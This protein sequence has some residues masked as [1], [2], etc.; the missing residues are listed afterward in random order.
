MFVKFAG[1]EVNT[2]HISRIEVG[3]AGG[4][5][6]GGDAH[7]VTVFMADGTKLHSLYESRDAADRAVD[8]LR[9]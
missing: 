1:Q 9:G 7:V 5:L 3:M 6:A 2:A 8:A 4:S